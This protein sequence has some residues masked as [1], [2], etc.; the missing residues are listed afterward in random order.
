MKRNTDID[1]D[2]G[3]VVLDTPPTTIP[4][5]RSVKALLTD[6]QERRKTAKREAKEKQQLRELQARFGERGAVFVQALR[7]EYPKGTIKLRSICRGEKVEQAVFRLHERLR[8][9]VTGYGAPATN[10]PGVAAV[11]IGRWLSR[12]RFD[13]HDSYEIAHMLVCWCAHGYADKIQ[14][15]MAERRL[16]SMHYRGTTC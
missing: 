13:A 9:E 1:L 3:A 8:K 14:V 15:S 4:R 16:A 7:R 6:W 5:R 10:D 12:D 11:A 2:G